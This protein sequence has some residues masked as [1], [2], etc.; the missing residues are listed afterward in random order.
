MNTSII[1]KT[2]QLFGSLWKP[3]SDESF[4][5]SVG[6]LR[7]RFVANNFAQGYLSGMRLLNDAVKDEL[8]TEEAANFTII[9]QGHHRVIG[10]KS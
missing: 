2:G 9:G 7:K 4:E 3:F 8:I 1:E 5:Q 6:L 10:T